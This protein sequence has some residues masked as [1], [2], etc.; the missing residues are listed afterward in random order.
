M[1][2]AYH[3]DFG[4]DVRYEFRVLPEA[5]DGQV[6][7]TI[8]DVIRLV[9]KDAVAPVIQQEAQRVLELGEGNPNLGLWRML[10]PSMRFKRDEA[11][12]QDL[13]TDDERKQDTIEVLIRPLDQ[14]MLIKLRGIGVGDCDCYTMYGACLLTALGVPCSLMT[15][16]AHPSRPNEFSHVYLVSYWNGER[17]PMDLSHGEYPGWE[18]PNL[19]RAKEWP[20]WSSRADLLMDAAI[21]LG[22]LAAVYFGLQWF[23]RIR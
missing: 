3:P 2:V 14:W 15:V 23:M 1:N 8:R 13:D 6:R 22:I 16:A 10:K 9:Q 5:P 19:G 4:Q 7:E 12:A 17:F 21:P 18:C 11:I 20:V